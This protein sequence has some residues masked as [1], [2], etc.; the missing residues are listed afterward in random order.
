MEVAFSPAGVPV[1][2]L[3]VGVFDLDDRPVDQHA[4]R[5]GDAGD[6]HDVDRH[7]HVVEGNEGQQHRDGDRD[8][9]HHRGR[10]M[11]EEKKD[12]QRDDDHLD[13]ELVLERPDRP[14]DEVGAVVGRN[15]LDPFR[16]RR[17][18]FLHLRLDPVDDVERVL[19]VAHHDDAAHVVAQPVEVGDAAPDLGAE[20]HVAD[21]LQQ[22]GNPAGARLHHHVFEVG[23]VL[24]IP[25]SPHHVLGAR[26]LDEASAHLVV[27]HPDRFGDHGER[28]AVGR[29]LVRVDRHLVLLLEAADG[30]DFRHPGNG[31]EGVAQRP[32]LVR[33]ELVERMRPGTVDQRVLVDPAHARGVRP[34]LGLHSLRQPRLD[35]GH[36][37]QH[38]GAGPVDV[39]AVLEDHVHVGEAEVR[40]PPDGLDMRSAQQRRHD[41][42][43]HL[44]LDDV[45][46]P[47]PLRVDDDLRV[48]QV[49]QRVET[50]LLEG[51][52]GERA[53]YAVTASSVR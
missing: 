50:D 33:A 5:D 44:V 28:N 11:P 19:A 52:D 25:A 9:R 12:H 39:G 24:Y 17:L 45:G 29:Q 26:E 3:V 49:R 30:C 18:Q 2:D 16:Q 48:G 22:D 42:V 15:E 13:D 20:R 53:Q 32:V 41:R 38:A 7:P 47:V 36:V 27:G 35:L 34:Q 46:G 23:R 31:L 21:I 14:V 6:A 8:D 1:V 4:D 37:F 43:R 10:G 51:V 40:E